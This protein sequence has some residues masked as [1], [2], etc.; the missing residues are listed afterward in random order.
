MNWS[1][2]HLLDALAIACVFMSLNCTTV[3]TE[4]VCVGCAQPS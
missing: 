1:L 4:F 2:Q 3:T